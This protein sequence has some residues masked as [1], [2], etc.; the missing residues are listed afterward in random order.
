MA[1]WRSKARADRVH[2]GSIGM[3]R[4][5]K[6]IRNA[7]IGLAGLIVVVLIAALIVVRTDWFRNYVREEIISATQD[8]TGGRVELGTFNLDLSQLR[9]TITG[10]VIHGN[11]PAG[12]APFVSVGKAEVRMRLCPDCGAFTK[13]PM[14]EW[15]GHRPMLWF[16]RTGAQTF[17]PRSRNQHRTPRGSRPLWTLRLAASK[18]PAACLLSNR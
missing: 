18:L 2:P 13:S 1:R 11:Q 3:S 7:V 5:G 9:A 6:W 10:L 14:W 16:W 17:R 8:A 12:A 15:I 4:T